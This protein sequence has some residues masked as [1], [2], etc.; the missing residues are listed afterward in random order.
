MKTITILMST[1]N[2]GHYLDEQLASIY[3]QENLEE[4]TINLVVRDDGSSDNT[5]DILK[6]WQDKLKIEF[7]IG[8][9]VGAR[10]SFF[11]LLR[12]APKSDY[13]AFCDQDDIWYKDKLY[14]SISKLRTKGLFFSNIEYIDTEGKPIGTNLLGKDFWVDLKRILMCNPANGCA[15]VWDQQLQNC[16]NKISEYTFTM[17]DEFM[18][19]IAYLFG[20]LQYD[21]VP[22]MGYRLHDSNVTQS[23]SIIKRMKIRKSIWL[24]RKKYSLDKRAKELLQYDLRNNDKEIL[25]LLS[26]YKKGFNRFKIVKTFSCEDAG[27]TR[28][29]KARMILGLL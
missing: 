23:K 18:C 12:N 25:F 19:T 2:G 15:M 16:A 7:H 4:Y 20:D 28:S 22:T 11:Y 24:D 13:Y 17:H 8:D 21:S 10:D 26:N 14:R 9:N 5:I 3:Y 29:F 27:I 6:S 1:Y